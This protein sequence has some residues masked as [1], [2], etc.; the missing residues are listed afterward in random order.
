MKMEKR[1]IFFLIF[2]LYYYSSFFLFFF[3]SRATP[4]TLSVHR[5]IH[6]SVADVVIL[7]KPRVKSKVLCD[8]LMCLLLIS[9]Y[10][11]GIEFER[12]DV[13]DVLMT[14][15]LKILNS[16]FEEKDCVLARCTIG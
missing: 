8:C 15:F 7:E 10:L 9:P 11:S 2:F 12:T 14:L 4:L 1:L 6:L 3:L 16:N 5:S 13:R